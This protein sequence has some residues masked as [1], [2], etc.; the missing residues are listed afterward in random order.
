MYPNS[1]RKLGIRADP[2]VVACDPL[3]K[4]SADASKLNLPVFRIGIRDPVLF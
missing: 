3:L 2:D 1:A 4:S